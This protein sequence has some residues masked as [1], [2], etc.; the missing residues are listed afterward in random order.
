MVELEKNIVGME[1]AL[2]LQNNIYLKLLFK[3]QPDVQFEAHPEFLEEYL[4]CDS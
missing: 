1:L 4:P 2:M 3:N